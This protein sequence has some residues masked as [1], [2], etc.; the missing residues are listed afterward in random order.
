MQKMRK[1]L[2]PIDFSQESGWAL[3]HAAAL[4]RE[5]GARVIA[6]HVIDENSVRD[7]LLSDIAA[8]DGLPFLLD[9][10]RAVPIDV[11][12]RERTLDL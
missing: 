2:V 12:L 5:T 6:L 7:V 3:R 9:S 1:I 10:Y 4:G 8:V 11:I